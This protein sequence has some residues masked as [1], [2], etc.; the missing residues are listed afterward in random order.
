[1]NPIL[2]LETKGKG[3]RALKYHVCFNAG[4]MIALPYCFLVVVARRDI[5]VTTVPGTEGMLFSKFQIAPKSN[6]SCR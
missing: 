3:R 1:M 4:G 5:P 6:I 2:S